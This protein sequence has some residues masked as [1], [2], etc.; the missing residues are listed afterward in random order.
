MIFREG[1]GAPGSRGER[2]AV[3][4]SDSVPPARYERKGR[5]CMCVSGAGGM[6]TNFGLSR[7]LKGLEEKGEGS[8][9]GMRNP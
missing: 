4:C 6:A 8:D 1:R 7:C 9:R 2:A 3:S 5:L